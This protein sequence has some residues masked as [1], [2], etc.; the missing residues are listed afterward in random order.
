MPPAN[1][2]ARVAEHRARDLL[3]DYAAHLERTEHGHVHSEDNARRFLRRFPDPQAWAAQPLAT[4]LVID[5][6]MSSFLS[7]LMLHGHLHPGYDY[8]V[9]RKLSS[10]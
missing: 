9:R 2:S 5:P 4:R 3:A 10:F 1:A 8:L 6:N 7:F